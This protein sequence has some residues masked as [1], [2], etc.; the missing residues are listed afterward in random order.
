MRNLPKDERVW[1]S[2]CAT[3]GAVRYVVTSKPARDR[4]FLYEKTEDGYIK[5]GKADSPGELAEA[6]NLPECL[7]SD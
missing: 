2:Y 1:V 6:H 3:G 4:Y 7:A 5:L